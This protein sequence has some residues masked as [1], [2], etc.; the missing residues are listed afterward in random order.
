MIFKPN[1]KLIC[2]DAKG[3]RY[4][5]SGRIYT[6][7]TPDGHKIFVDGYRRYSFLSTRFKQVDIFEIGDAVFLKDRNFAEL[8]YITNI[9]EDNRIELK[10]ASHGYP[11]PERC[12]GLYYG[13]SDGIYHATNEE[14]KAGHRL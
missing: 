9:L 10:T 13:G 5:K 2:V 14:I 7:S 1:T 4:L 12:W 11:V 6:A 3:Q 8:Y